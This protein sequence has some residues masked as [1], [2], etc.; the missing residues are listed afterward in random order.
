MTTLYWEAG[1]FTPK[2]TLQINRLLAKLILVRLQNITCF[3]LLPL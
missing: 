2:D 1:S 3:S